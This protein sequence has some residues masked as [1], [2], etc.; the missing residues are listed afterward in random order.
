MLLLTVLRDREMG[1]ER[2]EDR[3]KGRERERGSGGIKRER[4]RSGEQRK[5]K[6]EKVTDHLYAVVNRLTYT[7][8][9]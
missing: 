9:R 5:D 8:K 1:R 2:G 4:E 6:K 7:S 3:E